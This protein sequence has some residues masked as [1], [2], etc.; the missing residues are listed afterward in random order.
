M[1]WGGA[2]ASP[3]PGGGGREK[4]D[5]CLSPQ[6]LLFD[7]KATSA[8]TLLHEEFI[9]L[10]QR[11][12]DDL[13][14]LHTKG[15][16]LSAELHSLSPGAPGGGA[17]SA[18]SSPLGAAGNGAGRQEGLAA[19]LSTPIS[20]FL[21]LCL[22]EA[23]QADRLA[24]RLKTEVATPLEAL[25][26]KTRDAE[27]S[28]DH[29][30]EDASRHPASQSSPS[31][32]LAGSQRA[33]KGQEEA[34]DLAKTAS[35]EAQ[36]AAKKLQLAQEELKKA[37]D[38]L[39]ELISLFGSSVA[40]RLLQKAEERV[41]RARRLQ[42]TAEA[43][44]RSVCAADPGSSR[45]EPNHVAVVAAKPVARQN[46]RSWLSALVHAPPAAGLGGYASAAAA[47]SSQALV[48]SS[49]LATAAVLA[50]RASAE[51]FLDSTQQSARGRLPFVQQADAGAR[52][53]A[54]L[55]RLK[56]VPAEVAQPLLSAEVAAQLRQ[57]AAAAAGLGGEAAKNDEGRATLVNLLKQREKEL[58]TERTQR[59]ALQRE[60]E[61]IQDSA[62]ELRIREASRANET[63]HLKKEL[64]RLRSLL[65]ARH[66]EE[67]HDE[68]KR[69]KVLA[70]AA[71]TRGG[72]EGGGGAAAWSGATW[73]ECESRQG[74]GGG[75][76]RRKV[77]NERSGAEGRASSSFDSKGDA[78]AV[79]SQPEA[80]QLPVDEP[81]DSRDLSS[82]G[83]EDARGAKSPRETRP[84]PPSSSLPLVPDEI[85]KTE[86]RKDLDS[87]GSRGRLR[88]PLSQ[89]GKER[90]GVRLAMDRTGDETGERHASVHSG[91]LAGRMAADARA[92]A[93]VSW[94]KAQLNYEAFLLSLRRLP[95][96][97]TA[98]HL[99]SLP[100][101]QGRKH[102]GLLQPVALAPA[103]LSWAQSVPGEPVSSHSPSPLPAAPVSLFWEHRDFPN[104]LVSLIE[105]A[106]ASALPPSLY[107]FCRLA[108]VSG[109]GGA[110]TGGTS[111][112][113]GGGA[114]RRISL[115]QIQQESAKRRQ[116]A[117]S[118]RK[119]T[120]FSEEDLQ[121]LA[122]E[123][124]LLCAHQQSQ[125]AAFASLVADEADQD[126][127]PEEEREGRGGGAR[128][129][130][131]KSGFAL[132]PLPGRRAAD[133]VR[134]ERP[135]APA[136]ARGGSSDEARESAEASSSDDERAGN[137]HSARESVPREDRAGRES[138][139]SSVAGGVKSEGR[140]GR[141][142]TVRRTICQL[143]FPHGLAGALAARRKSRVAEEKHDVLGARRAGGDEGAEEGH[144]VAGAVGH[145]SAS[146]AGPDA[147]SARGAA[148]DPQGGNPR[149]KEE[150]RA[151]LR[152][153]RRRRTRSTRESLAPFGVPVDA[154]IPRT[155]VW[156]GREGHHA[157]Q[158][159]ASG[160]RRREGER[161]ERGCRGFCDGED[162]EG[163]D[164]RA[165]AAPDER[166]KREILLNWLV[167]DSPLLQSNLKLLLQLMQLARIAFQIP[168]S[169]SNKLLRLLVPCADCV[170]SPGATSSL[171]PFDLRFRVIRLTESWQMAAAPAVSHATVSA[172]D[173]ERR[174]ARAPP[175][176]DVSSLSSRKK[177][178]EP[179][180]RLRFAAKIHFAPRQTWGA[181]G[182]G[183]EGAQRSFSGEASGAPFAP[184]AAAAETGGGDSRGG[185]DGRGAR[186]RSVSPSRKSD[187]DSVASLR[188]TREREKREKD[189]KSE[190]GKAGMKSAL[191]RFNTQ[192]TK[193]MFGNIVAPAGE[194]LPWS[195]RGSSEPKG[196]GAGRDKPR[197]G[198]P[199]PH[200]L[201]PVERNLH[202]FHG[203]NGEDETAGY[204]GAEDSTWDRSRPV[205]GAAL[206]A[207]PPSALAF[208]PVYR[209]FVK[210]QIQL[211]YVAT[212]MRF[213]RF[214]RFFFAAALD[215]SACGALSPAATPQG[216]GARSESLSPAGRGRDEEGR[217]ARAKRVA[218]TPH[219]APLHP[220]S[221]GAFFSSLAH[222]LRQKAKRGSARAA[223]WGRGDRG[224]QR[225]WGEDGDWELVGE[226][227]EE[228]DLYSAYR[229]P[230][231]FS[232]L[233][234]RSDGKDE[235]A[236]L[237]YFILSLLCYT[238]PPEAPFWRY[239]EDGEDEGERGEGGEALSTPPARL[240][241]DLDDVSAAISSAAS[242][243]LL[244]LRQLTA[245]YHIF[246]YL[247]ELDR[248]VSHPPS[249]AF[250][251]SRSGF[252][253]CGAWGDPSVEAELLEVDVQVL[254]EKRRAGE[255]AARD[256][257]RHAS[258]LFQED[259][260]DTVWELQCTRRARNGQ[261][262]L[263]RLLF[264]MTACADLDAA[265]RIALARRCMAQESRACDR[266][267]PE[268]ALEG[269][270]PHLGPL[271]RGREGKSPTDRKE[272]R[273][274]EERK[275]F[276]LRPPPRR[277]GPG[278]DV[279]DGTSAE[280]VSDSDVSGVFH[281]DCDAGPL[282]SMGPSGCDKARQRTASRL[283]RRSRSTR[284]FSMGGGG[285]LSALGG[286]SDCERG[287]GGEETE[288]TTPEPPTVRSVRGARSRSRR[289]L[290][291]RSLGP[292]RAADGEEKGAGD[293]GA[294]G[295]DTFTDL[296]GLPREQLLAA[297]WALD[298]P[299]LLSLLL[300][301]SKCCL[302][303][304]SPSGLHID[305][306]VLA[307]G[308]VLVSQ[309][310]Q[311][312][313]D[314]TAISSREDE[315]R[316]VRGGAP[317]AVPATASAGA[318]G[319]GRFGPGGEDG[320]VSGG[321]DRSTLFRLKHASRAGSGLLPLSLQSPAL[322]LATCLWRQTAGSSPLPDLAGLLQHAA[323][324]R[325][326]A[327]S[328][329]KDE[330]RQTPGGLP[331]PGEGPESHISGGALSRGE[332]SQ[333]AFASSPEI[334]GK[335][336]RAAEGAL[337]PESGAEA[338]QAKAVPAPL[339]RVGSLGLPEIRQAE[340]LGELHVVSTLLQ[341]A[342]NQGAG[343]SGDRSRETKALIIGDRKEL[344]AGF[345]P[346]GPEVVDAVSEILCAFP[347]FIQKPFAG[348]DGHI[349][350]PDIVLASA[351][352]A[353]GS[354]ARSGPGG[355]P[356]MEP[357]GPPGDAEEG[358]EEAGGG[359]SPA[360][361]EAKGRKE[362]DPQA[363]GRAFSRKSIFGGAGALSGLP[364]LRGL[365]GDDDES[366]ADADVL[367]EAERFSSQGDGEK[368]PQGP[369]SRSRSVLTLARNRRKSA[370]PAA[371][372]GVAGAGAPGAGRPFV[373]RVVPAGTDAG[374]EEG[375]W[376]LHQRRASRLIGETPVSWF[377]LVY[378]AWQRRT[379]GDGQVSEA[380][381]GK[382]ERGG[383]VEEELRGVLFVGKASSERAP[384]AGRS[385]EEQVSRVWAALENGV[386]RVAL[387]RR[388]F[389]QVLKAAGW[390]GGDWWTVDEKQIFALS[391]D[392]RGAAWK[393]GLRL[394]PSAPSFFFLSPALP[395]RVELQQEEAATGQLLALFFL[396]L[397]H[398][399]LQDYRRFFEPVV[400]PSVLRLW[401]HLVL[402]LLQQVTQFAASS[403]TSASLSPSSSY[404][405]SPRFPAS[406]VTSPPGALVTFMLPSGAP[407]RSLAASAAAPPGA[408]RTAGG[409]SLDFRAF[410]AGSAARGGGRV[411]GGGEHFFLGWRHLEEED[412]E[413]WKAWVKSGLAA[414]LQGSQERGKSFTA[415]ARTEG[416]SGQAA[417]EEDPDGVSGR[418]RMRQSSRRREREQ[419]GRRVRLSREADGAQ[420]A[421]L[422]RE[423]GAEF[424]DDRSGGRGRQY[425]NRLSR[426]NLFASYA[427]SSPSRA[428]HGFSPSFFLS[429]SAASSGS[430]G[431]SRAP[432]LVLPSESF[433][434]DAH[435]LRLSLVLRGPS[436][437]EDAIRCF[438]YQSLAQAA[439]R[440]FRLAF[441]A[442]EV[443]REK[444]RT[445]EGCSER[446]REWKRS[447]DAA[448]PEDLLRCCEEEQDALLGAV[449]ASLRA[450]SAHVRDEL[451]LYAPVFGPLLPLR[452]EFAFL[453]LSS[454]R[455]FV[456]ALLAELLRTAVWAGAGGEA[457][458]LPARGDAELLEVLGAFEKL[459]REVTL[460]RVTA[461]PPLAVPPLLPPLA[462]AFL[463]SLSV[464]LNS[465]STTLLSFLE[466]DTF[467]PVNPPLRGFS[468][469]A[470]D[471][472]HVVFNLAS[473][474]LE[475]PAPID[476]V[477]PP[478]L[479]FLRSFVVAFAS[480]CALSPAD[481][482]SERPATASLLPLL[483]VEQRQL[484]NFLTL[485]T[486][487]GR[488]G[489]KV[490]AS[491]QSAAMLALARMGEGDEFG[492]K[493]KKGQLTWSSFVR[494]GQRMWAEDEEQKRERRE[495]RMQS[496]GGPANYLQPPAKAHLYVSDGGES[497]AYESGGASDPEA[498]AR[499]K[500]RKKSFFQVFETPGKRSKNAGGAESGAASYPPLPPSAGDRA[501]A[502][503]RRRLS[504]AGDGV[505]AQ[506]SGGRGEEP[507]TS[508]GR[509]R[510]NSLLKLKPERQTQAKRLGPDLALL[511]QGV[512]LAESLQRRQF[513][514]LLQAE[515]GAVGG[516]ETEGPRRGDRR[517][518]GGREDGKKPKK[519]GDETGTRELS[520][521]GV[522][523]TGSSGGDCVGSQRGKGV[524]RW[525]VRLHNVAMFLQQLP[526][527]QEKVRAEL[528]R[529]TRERNSKDEEIVIKLGRLGGAPSTKFSDDES[530]DA[531]RGAEFPG[532]GDGAPREMKAARTHDRLCELA[533]DAEILGL[534]E[535]LEKSI[536]EVRELLHSTA[537]KVCE[538]AAAYI[539]YYELQ[540]DIFDQL[541]AGDD[542]S[543]YTLERV[544]AAFPRT[545][546]H[547]FVAAPEDYQDD[548]AAAF[549]RCLIQAWC[550]VVTELGYSGHIFSS[551][552]VDTLESD[553]EAV[554]HYM[555][556][557]EISP[558]FQIASAAGENLS[559]DMLE[560][561]NDFFVMLARD[562]ACLAAVELQDQRE[563]GKAAAADRDGAG[564][565]ERSRSFFRGRSSRRWSSLS[566]RADPADEG[567]S[568]R[569]SPSPF[570]LTSRG[571]KDA[572]K[573]E[574][575]TGTEPGDRERRG[576][577]ELFVR[578]GGREEEDNRR[579]E[580]KKKKKGPI[581]SVGRWVK[582]NII[583]TSS[584]AAAE[585]A[586]HS[587]KEESFQARRSF[588]DLTID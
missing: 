482:E 582:K 324:L 542:F 32:R 289:R 170:W 210:R 98:Y 113:F 418:S 402:L 445:G 294:A 123:L 58:E 173:L 158:A 232:S 186:P 572:E 501:G 60:K 204:S 390:F 522:G 129:K 334:A 490:D 259:E 115:F 545:V 105:S 225:V 584:S 40:P 56:R 544:V 333:T 389:I 229:P 486:P 550:L 356:G 169:S 68:E 565:R 298:V 423:E 573:R 51:C 127:A 511:L 221:S 451:L 466:K 516:E 200:E 80:T 66:G 233:Y 468:E 464:R 212:L 246:L 442:L 424:S 141:R 255:A 329:L 408:Q 373:S 411:A 154:W 34:A 240:L 262:M 575:S 273:P 179:Q 533:Q 368:P 433:G 4:A 288:G 238:K 313:V 525:L 132:P 322:L 506:G 583:G 86:T 150:S 252:P 184:D 555:T 278:G 188:T 345:A 551:E 293:K 535:V 529:R 22:A 33:R 163:E 387:E 215:P 420:E 185:A 284:L 304:R 427:A 64:A 397:L 143:A 270:E 248:L 488:K 96:P 473:A 81:T 276:F 438:V 518:S 470:A 201:P 175:E 223:A 176:P 147:L 57:S 24:S 365:N 524:L 272:A 6:Q 296:L 367:S 456:A 520:A 291:G 316:R 100:P 476:W 416:T 35:P 579:Q 281:S 481:A 385:A 432:P 268:L 386:I 369:Q 84:C 59:L 321:V 428:H 153:P 251:S 41:E 548:A 279:S 14:A 192:A 228:A 280:F 286:A 448:V 415:S 458:L 574:A 340:L 379:K 366:G 111:S 88:D 360:A 213:T 317:G 1:S 254:S 455:L 556:E 93:E 447:T 124:L 493:K 353:A 327:E 118:A 16:A 140:S 62:H 187:G 211:V 92:S 236:A 314:P 480:S 103:S 510:S 349:E 36:K 90:E 431:G 202:L 162:D 7:V 341:K 417:D 359:G 568:R 85:E 351:G 585:G 469:K 29:L 519:R 414:L 439:S 570:F 331:A 297:F 106:A 563:A 149:A 403:Q 199:A 478:F 242:L 410:A 396:L 241:F 70:S 346:V 8:W 9:S 157:C 207:C 277:P 275:R 145:A 178:K 165:L 257:R 13:R 494:M 357:S 121:L 205:G 483:A 101:E 388:N 558:I 74:G 263:Q 307:Q 332:K 523:V 508:R 301:L 87:R 453:V 2:S 12:S 391:R 46:P 151:K 429:R 398:A 243:D 393:R 138:S 546:E 344:G 306:P 267:T 39:N 412:L 49:S 566:P 407:L 515:T 75:E 401:R 104:F 79:A 512:D 222:G 89:P 261:E 172:R 247:L 198:A 117:S 444:Q 310:A 25:L 107:D 475:S 30:D 167:P 502:S 553:L 376:T 358:R 216:R 372:D 71:G 350:P 142:A 11:F 109:L 287:G 462:P 503:P 197:R 131:Q 265:C 319:A 318:E 540:H 380:C 384:A 371:A 180:S 425:S 588:S 405:G 235:R 328:C 260:D 110:A 339:G 399:Q 3:P 446:T 343:A 496:A 513:E 342:I 434:E 521:S 394:S 73:S 437:L 258:G 578:A 191:K 44:N 552:D 541:Y 354:S 528:E 312:G 426:L 94:L 561:G 45:E 537:L 220:A 264:M 325:R 509:E 422:D 285:L 91:D 155:K 547:F 134:V 19:G 532:A 436:I 374:E 139:F 330:Q 454:A 77:T 505:G 472:W 352:A 65:E 465:V 136:G 282:G 538:T 182:T 52:E 269:I 459:N 266:E 514:V 253:P 17:Q 102:A 531:A 576:H 78:R 69:R 219:A 76:L 580:A 489:L 231:L 302:D 336:E 554:R 577:E 61:A 560:Q 375:D 406:P 108:A 217:A 567:K 498:Q 177:K 534:E 347:N 362:K 54:A 435:R 18:L 218:E 190:T 23:N 5:F 28:E 562:G 485:L 543:T 226:D 581:G 413:C 300:L 315:W 133:K 82:V 206:A 400:L 137:L 292:G 135:A 381:G 120:D 463:S 491:L 237:L 67:D 130:R 194:A 189:A 338:L 409:A 299:L 477:L 395:S 63:D 430:R 168:S 443:Y 363:Q 305:A 128:K 500:S 126:A 564:A 122:Y 507:R 174:A 250:S 527:L 530:D 460:S 308:L 474:V 378:C 208:D 166:G 15:V 295:G 471:C 441:E 53:T 209:S 48:F 377:A 337:S 586:A 421:P 43:E 467:V 116:R 557:N 383:G 452:N 144:H 450:F 274:N 42:A 119:K 234:A 326:E 26:E 195:P 504:G 38:S 271:E 549:M 348:A 492:R 440:E 245:F 320:E 114:D 382:E 214:F 484:K 461:L 161:G 559:L 526:K 290:E 196:P 152:S 370:A 495:K 224:A 171:H 47:G 230:P 146:P 361:G 311:L 164:A 419:E 148:G 159:G 457:E 31:S 309:A 335:G 55:G 125:Y 569:A 256:E 112:P 487:E 244:P 37:E 249:A 499:R 323:E 95:L 27:A 203:R 10:L 587:A 193:N 83:A 156:R 479:K 571:R 20:S 355:G 364:G 50:L 303:S 536:G 72:A 539:V 227:D 449:V 392:P 21:S 517:D 160:A 97:L 183:R 283:F 181:A 497:S 404:R 99:A 239:G